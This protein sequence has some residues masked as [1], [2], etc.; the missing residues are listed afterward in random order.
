MPESSWARTT[1]GQA[2]TIAAQASKA[3]QNLPT[4][5]PCRALPWHVYSSSRRQISSVAAL[6]FMV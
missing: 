2:S 5:K 4:C 3:A 6:W 1:T